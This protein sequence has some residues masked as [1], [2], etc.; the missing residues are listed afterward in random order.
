MLCL[1]L[2]TFCLFSVASA[3]ALQQVAMQ[4]DSPISVAGGWSWKDCG[5]DSDAIKV[6]SIEVSPDPPQAGKDLTVT[7][8]GTASE[9][10]DDGALVEVTVK[11]GLIQLLKKE[12]DICDEARKANA[13]IQCPIEEGEHRVVQTVSLPK[14]IPP[15]KFKVHVEG[16]TANEDDML[17]LNLDIDFMNRLYNW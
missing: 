13:S 4:A 3:G 17:C 6:K 9:T 15:A 12:F 11:L 16:W 14:E 10:I 1:F 7:A 2:A 8:I 5:K